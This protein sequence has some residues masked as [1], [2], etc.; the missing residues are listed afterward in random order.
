MS[1]VLV[2]FFLPPFLGR[3]LGTSKVHNTGPGLGYRFEW[4]AQLVT[5]DGEERRQFL[6]PLPLRMK[7]DR[8]RTDI[9]D[10]VFL[11]IFVFEYG[12]GYG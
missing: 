10:I 4:Y 7:T 6:G 1:W 5:A 3:S 9:T 12:V 8:I 2:S 11:F